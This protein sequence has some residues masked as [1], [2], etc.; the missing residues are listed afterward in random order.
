MRYFFISS[1]MSIERIMR[2]IGKHMEKLKSSLIAGGV[3]S[4]NSLVLPLK[5]TKPLHDPTILSLMCPRT[6]K[7]G[8]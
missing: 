3:T 2:N 7:T 8:A 4:E 1:R 6:M 5:V